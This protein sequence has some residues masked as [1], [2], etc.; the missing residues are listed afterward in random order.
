MF[1]LDIPTILQHSNPGAKWCVRG[2]QHD[3][4]SLEWM[5]E[6][7]AP[8]EQELL[9]AELAAAKAARS[10][11]IKTEAQA[12]I[13]AAWPAWM[14]DNCALGLYDGEY[15][16]TKAVTGASNA[17]P[18]V[19][20]C[21]GHGWNTGD[22]VTVES[23]GGNAA[24]NVADNLITV[25]DADS[26]SLNGVAGD[27]EYTSGGTVKRQKPLG[28]K[29]DISVFRAAS[30]AAEAAVDALSDVGDVNAFTW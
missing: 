5:D 8:T 16:A 24:A 3:F 14:Q 22:R 25:V 28:I 27:G 18:V 23:V 11:T 9:D 13:L 17:S 29:N 21:A 19:V 10:A 4:A 2:D 20:T 7:A 6:S 26:F 15:S 30:N 12:R 1:T